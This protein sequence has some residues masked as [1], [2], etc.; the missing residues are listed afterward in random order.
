M[1][2]IQ[3]AALASVVLLP[4]AVWLV[5][6]RLHAERFDLISRRT[7]AIVLLIFE[8]G[9]LAAKFVLPESTLADVLPMHLCDWALFAVAWALWFRHQRGFDLAYFW[10]LAGTIQALLTPA[11]DLTLHWLRLFGFFFSHALI[12]AGV[13]H[14]LITERLRPWP[15]SLLRVLLVSEIYLGTA[16]LVNWLTGSN[17]GFLFQ[18]PEQPSLLDYF[19][20]TPWLYV[21][22][23]NLIA[24]FAFGLL[25]LPWA[26]ADLLKKRPV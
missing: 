17:Y 1:H 8:V 13:L 4:L 19:S 12:V 3:I 6:R 2:P 10:G 24:W 15:S 26:I 9:E 14:L 25:Y 20:D 16:L 11:L 5:S 22:Q 23:I 21:V 7:L 18:R